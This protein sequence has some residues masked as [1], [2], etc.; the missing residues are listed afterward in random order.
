MVEVLNPRSGKRQRRSVKCCR[1]AVLIGVAAALGAAASPAHVASQ[2]PSAAPTAV[3]VP[4]T[5]FVPPYGSV[6]FVLAPPEDATGRAFVLEVGSMTAEP[7]TASY[8]A[9]ASAADQAGEIPGE[10]TLTAPDG[11]VV[12]VQSGCQVETNWQPTEV[13]SAPLRGN[14]RKSVYFAT[15]PAGYTQPLGACPLPIGP[16]SPPPSGPLGTPGG[17]PLP[18]PPGTPGVCDARG[19][20]IGGIGGPVRSYCEL[21]PIPPVVPVFPDHTPVTQFPPPEQHRIAVPGGT[22]LS[23][24]DDSVTF[25]DPR[26]G[27]DTP[28]EATVTVRGGGAGTSVSFDDLGL[29]IVASGGSVVVTT[30]PNPCEPAGDG[31]STVVCPGVTLDP[32]SNV[33][34]TVDTSHVPTQHTLTVPPG[35]S[36]MGFPDGTILPQNWTAYALGPADP[37]SGFEQLPPR[38]VATGGAGYWVYVSADV[39]QRERIPDGA[40]S[41]RTVSLPPGRWTLVGNPFNGEAAASGADDVDIYDPVTSSYRSVATLYA[42][43]G[44]WAYSASGGALTLAP[45]GG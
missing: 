29:A 6:T 40:P 17:P 45:A 15:R 26:S 30:E 23:E 19:L 1:F 25:Y 22:C 35:W 3:Q 33:E 10:L 20:G 8:A 38:S 21:F 4:G 7:V 43:Q 13:C 41:P 18:G 2:Q 14:P 42:G 12:E 44:A 28:A 16:Y 9:T 39:T 36:L 5:A 32:A 37:T 11:A 24:D 34:F 31:F 27:P